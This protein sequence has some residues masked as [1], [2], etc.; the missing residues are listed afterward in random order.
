[1]II[2]A[3]ILLYLW[4][5]FINPHKNPKRHV[6]LLSLCVLLTVPHLPDRDLKGTHRLTADTLLRIMGNGKS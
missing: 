1:M 2:I 5:N 4:I 3:N 6:V